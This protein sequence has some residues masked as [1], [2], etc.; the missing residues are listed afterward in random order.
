MLINK[1]TI[2]EWIKKNMNWDSISKMKWSEYFSNKIKCFSQH[3][4]KRIISNLPPLKEDINQIRTLSL[5]ISY[6]RNQIVHLQMS[7]LFLRELNLSGKLL[8]ARLKINKGKKEVILQNLNLVKVTP[9][10][11]HLRWRIL[12]LISWI[13]LRN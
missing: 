6:L 12:T 8:K 7:L 1:K 5:L 10:K 4:W 2:I 9:V 11:T 13:T 3:S